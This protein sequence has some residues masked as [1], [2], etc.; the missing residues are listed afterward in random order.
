M[1]PKRGITLLPVSKRLREGR[2]FSSNDFAARN[3]NWEDKIIV[4]STAE[5]FC[6]ICA[7][8]ETEPYSSA[9]RRLE[10]HAGVHV[11]K[12]RVVSTDEKGVAAQGEQRP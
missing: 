5:P 8:P 9:E 2:D 1:R 4:K 3:P 12:G 7:K 10:W 6:A 11:Q